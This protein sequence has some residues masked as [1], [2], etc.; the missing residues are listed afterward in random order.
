MD[1]GVIQITEWVDQ[2]G[3]RF[4]HA[5]QKGPQFKTYEL[6][7]SGFFQ[8]IFLG[9]SWLQ[10]TE[11]SKSNIKDTVCKELKKQNPKQNF[12]FVNQY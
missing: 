9:P 5:A 8:L 2:D 4:H 10:V 1:K 12:S 11:T 6:F 3:A 7:I